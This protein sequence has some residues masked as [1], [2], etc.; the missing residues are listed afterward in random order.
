[1]FKQINF[2]GKNFPFSF[3]FIFISRSYNIFCLPLLHYN[4]TGQKCGISR[5]FTSSSNC[6]W[7]CRDVFVVLSDKMFFYY[8]KLHGFFVG[9]LYIYT[10][11]MRNRKKNIEKHVNVPLSL[12]KMFLSYELFDDNLCL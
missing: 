7:D 11:C 1:M 8:N 5:K 6:K 2:C 4:L 10:G 9:Y 3:F 12:K